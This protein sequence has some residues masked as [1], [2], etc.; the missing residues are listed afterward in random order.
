LRTTD[1]SIAVSDDCDS[2]PAVALLSITI[3]G[4][5]IPNPP[6]GPLSGLDVQGASFGTDDRQFQLRAEID[7]DGTSRVYTITYQAQDS[8]GKMT[9]VSEQVL[10]PLAGGGS[11]AAS[12]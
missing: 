10:V 3:S 7:A 4:P 6:S 12:V 1:A 2:A 9:I 8:S 5:D 11:R